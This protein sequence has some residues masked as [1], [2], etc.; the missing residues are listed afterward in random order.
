[1]PDFQND[2]AAS[3]RRLMSGPRP[4]IVSILSATTQESQARLI[5]NLAASIH[6]G[7]S[8]VLVAYAGRN[9]RETEA[10]YGLGEAPSL[11]DAIYRR[12]AAK[13]IIQSAR[14]GFSVMRLLHEQQNTLPLDNTA[15]DK[16]DRL[17]AKLANEYEIVLVDAMLNRSHMLPIQTLNNSDILIQLSRHPDSIKE[18]YRLIKQVYSQLGRRP[19]GILVNGATE[20]Q[21]QIVFSNIFQVAK[22]YLKVELEFIGAIPPDEHLGRA[23]KLGR[24]VIDAFPMAAA[25]GA[26]KSLAQRLDY[27][28][29]LAASAGLASFI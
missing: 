27:R 11:V 19:F 24:A 5:T 21:A 9:T 1:M 22:R 2:Q 26:F 18:A 10:E 12:S 17:F 14:Q 3:L 4:R 6:N 29:S 8:D 7:G 23:A 25:S 16:L 15:A 28:N 20:E 13:N